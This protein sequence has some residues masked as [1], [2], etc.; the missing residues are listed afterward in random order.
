MNE[1]VEELFKKYNKYSIEKLEIENT[2]E[3]FLNIYDTVTFD[4]V[5]LALNIKIINRMKKGNSTSLNNVKEYNS[6]IKVCIRKNKEL[7]EL[8]DEKY[9]MDI[10]LVSSEIYNLAIQSLPDEY[11][12]SVQIYENILIKVNYIIKNKLDTVIELL[13]SKKYDI[14]F[15]ND[16]VIQNRI[17]ITNFAKVLDINCS[18]FR[19]F[20]IG[21]GRI[22]A[23]TLIK[24]L[25]LFNVK[26]Y[27]ELKD[28]ALNH[29]LD[30]PD[31]LFCGL[32]DITFLRK[33]IDDNKIDVRLLNKKLEIK[34][35]KLT[36][37][38]GGRNR[39]T[40]EV[41]DKLLEIFNVKDYKELKEKSMNNTL[42]IPESLCN[43]KYDITFL[44]DY[45]KHNG[46]STRKLA[47][48]L[49]ITLAAMH[50]YLLGRSNIP[51]EVL[52]KL[53]E[54]FAVKNYEELKEKSINNT[55]ERKEYL[56][57]VRYNIKFFNNYIKYSGIDYKKLADKLSVSLATIYNYLS[58][59][60]NISKDV[61]DKLLEI[62]DVKDYEEFARKVNKHELQIPECLIKKE[63]KIYD[64]QKGVNIEVL[65]KLI[66]IENIS[67]Q[68]Y[69]IILLLFGGM[70]NKYY[71]V[72]NISSFLKTDKKHVLSILKKCS[73][74]Y[75]D[76]FNDELEE[77]KIKLLQN[78]KN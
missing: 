18:N 9:N 69:F 28:K 61:L 37:Y 66:D 21:K 44:N 16:Y 50:N 67:K 53:L 60:C 13:Q 14:S 2:I 59:R 55:L 78:D 22:D 39:A 75:A 63:D 72:E 42:E 32:Y 49:S 43:I 36:D 62:F 30:V 6:Y 47:D 74:I 1:L 11:D 5:S 15:L 76:A 54:I 38:L 10:R 24:L 27:E 3:R 73:K 12:Y 29:E 20:L 65:L 35:Q 64:I 34:Q 48:E 25:D 4:R 40:K 45:I 41:L 52:D 71:S 46:I 51:K 26:S 58:G 77:S 17:N 33:F 7:K 23:N 70:D 56:Y 31:I 19:V 8:L 57:N 68:D